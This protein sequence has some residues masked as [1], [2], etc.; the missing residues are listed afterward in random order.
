MSIEIA[1]S[2]LCV[3]NLHLEAGVLAT[4]GVLEHPNA[5]PYMQSLSGEVP[6][7][8]E[9]SARVAAIMGFMATEAGCDG[10][11]VDL[12]RR[13]G[14]VHDV[15]KSTPRLRPYSRDFN[16]GWEPGQVV[17]FRGAHT[18]DGEEL[19]DLSPGLPHRP[20]MRVSAGSH[21]SRL[22]E[23]DP[24]YRGILHLLQVSDRLDAVFRAYIEDTEGV[25]SIDDRVGFVFEKGRPHPL[26]DVAD[27]G[28]TKVQAR[29]LVY[30]MLAIPKPHLPRQ[31]HSS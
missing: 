16:Q 24:E 25:L 15:G 7:V 12:I 30:S 27:L 2:G 13:T 5:H 6:Q 31:R 20:V 21:H 28:G 4:R 11:T 26:D 1:Q 8:F 29:D 10:Y 19:I 23:V 9:H 14:G 18:R 3:P 22:S 17:W